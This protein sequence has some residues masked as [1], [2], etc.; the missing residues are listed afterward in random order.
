MVIQFLATLLFQGFHYKF[1]NGFL[2]THGFV[3]IVTIK[4]HGHMMNLSQGYFSFSIQLCLEAV[5]T[6]CPYN[7]K[8]GFSLG[9]WNIVFPEIVMLI[10]GF[11][12]NSLH[13]LLSKPTAK[14]NTLFPET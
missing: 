12:K 14:V 10:G 5:D 1:Q 8:T 6:W 9:S 11:P 2:G 4:D 3:D 13:L 7:L